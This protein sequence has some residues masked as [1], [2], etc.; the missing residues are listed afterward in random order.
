MRL[1]RH[2]H[3][4]GAYLSDRVPVVRGADRSWCDLPEAPYRALFPTAQRSHAASNSGAASD[5]ILRFLSS[6]VIE[7]SLLSTRCSGEQDSP[8]S[9]LKA[10]SVTVAE[11]LLMVPVAGVVNWFEAKRS[12]LTE[13]INQLS[14]WSGQHSTRPSDSGVREAF[15]S[16]R[17]A[18]KCGI[19]SARAEYRDNLVAALNNNPRRTILKILSR[20]SRN[21]PQCRRGL[22]KQIQAETQ[23]PGWR[24][25]R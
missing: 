17:K 5:G 14:C 16:A 3:V 20:Q 11:E 8:F 7:S 24:F 12:A 1:A 15:A 23:G 10:S 22:W 25:W 2:W 21:S 9:A 19:R 4:K 13:L 18:L 6:F